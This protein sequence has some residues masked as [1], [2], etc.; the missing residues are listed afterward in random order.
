[1]KDYNKMEPVD[2]EKYRSAWKNERS[3]DEKK[4]SSNEIAAFLKASSKSIVAFFRKGLLFDIILKTALLVSLFILIFLMSNQIL[5]LLFL[6]II[7]ALSLMWQ[8]VVLRKLSYS[9]TKLPS[10]ID[11]LRDYIDFYYR[12]YV[13]SIYVGALSASLFFLIGSIY[14][15]YFKYKDI[16]TFE[17][18]DFIVMSIGIL[19]SYGLS[20][21]VGLKYNTFIIKQLEKCVKEIEEN[22]INKAR[23]KMQY[24]TR[25]KIILILGIAIITGLIF[26]LFVIINLTT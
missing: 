9:E 18:D 5:F 23:I 14:Y 1:M 4:L 22:T 13:S 6:S 16:P 12:Y 8:I 11:K 19:L 3:F 15:F 7:G 25:K 21:I 10:V 26:L 17:T 20:A 24:T 2:I